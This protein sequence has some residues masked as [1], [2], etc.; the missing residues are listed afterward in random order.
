MT[1]KHL[2]DSIPHCQDLFARVVHLYHEIT[3][4]ALENESPLGDAD[5]VVLALH[6]VDLAESAAAKYQRPPCSSSSRA[7]RVG[8]SACGIRYS[9]PVVRSASSALP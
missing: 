4:K 7:S 3:A 6:L 5:A 9:G 8:F 1:N 2:V